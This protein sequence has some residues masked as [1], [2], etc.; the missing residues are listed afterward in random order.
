M[1]L[2]LNALVIILGFLVSLFGKKAGVITGWRLGYLSMVSG[3]FLAF[4]ILLIFD[5]KQAGLF[6]IF[7]T[8][9][10]VLE[11]ILDFLYKKISGERLFVYK[12]LTLFGYGSLLSFPFWGAA[13]L[14]FYIIGNLI[15]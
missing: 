7:G 13:G 11:A 12:H 1:V 4:S 3:I 14:M 5:T 15:K 9:G 6:V 8:V 2:F 10:M